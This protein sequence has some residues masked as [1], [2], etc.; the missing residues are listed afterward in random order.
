MHTIHLT[1]KAKSQNWEQL[2]LALDQ[3]AEH[4]KLT[5]HDTYF[6]TLICEEWFFNIVQHGFPSSFHKTGELTDVIVKVKMDDLSTVELYFEDEGTPFNPF[7]N[8][9]QLKE[10]VT[11]SIEQQLGGLGLYF[12]VN[13][14]SRFCY[15]YQYDKNCSTMYYVIN[16]KER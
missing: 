6:I 7:V 14:L 5:S 1:L 10:T 11:A 8:L 2:R 16:Q 15:S 9:K 3:F 13:Q 12:I 4:H